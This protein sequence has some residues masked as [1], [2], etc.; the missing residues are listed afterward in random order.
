MKAFELGSRGYAEPVAVSDPHHINLTAYAVGEA[1]DLAVTIINKTHSTTH[2]VTDAAV[3]IHTEGFVP[4]SAEYMVL[5]D[6]DPGNAALMTA[7]LGG[8]SIRNDALWQGKWTSL[9]EIKN[10]VIAVTVQSTT[11]VIVRIHAA[12][13][14]AKLGA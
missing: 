5:T 11:A 6:G 12:A 4:G 7:T 13:S 1:K 14:K 9:G 2:D 10:G 8:A 3:E